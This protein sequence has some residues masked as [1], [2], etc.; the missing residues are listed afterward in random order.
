VFVCQP[1]H[2]ADTQSESQKRKDQEWSAM[3][4]GVTG[5]L[6]RSAYAGMHRQGQGMFENIVLIASLLSLIFLRKSSYVQVKNSV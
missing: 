4:A 3:Q 6:H 2:E 5:F 1:K